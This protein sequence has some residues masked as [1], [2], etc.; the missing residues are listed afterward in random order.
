L[1]KLIWGNFY[2]FESSKLGS[3]CFQESS[4]QMFL[5]DL[6]LLVLKVGGWAKN[7]LC[8]TSYGAPKHEAFKSSMRGRTKKFASASHWVFKQD[9]RGIHERLSAK[10]C[11]W[12]PTFGAKSWR[13]RTFF[14]RL[15]I[16][17]NILNMPS[18]NF[19]TFSLEL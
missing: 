6:Q 16:P 2:T 1:K 9:V 14:L 13:P 18:A 17:W 19:F 10:K 5:F 11:V 4:K 15:A 8:L 7:I 3:S 12:P